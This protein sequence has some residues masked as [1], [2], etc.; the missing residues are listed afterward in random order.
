MALLDFNKIDLNR[1]IRIGL[2]FSLFILTI[3]S[4]VSYYSLQKFID[5]SRLVDHT[6]E[7]LMTLENTLSCMRAAESGQRGYI[8]TGNKIFLENY[9][10][11]ESQTLGLCKKIKHLTADNPIQQQDAELLLSNVATRYRKMATT[12][13]YYDKY[14][15]S[16]EEMLKEGRDIMIQCRNIIN[17]MKGEELR[18][19]EIRTTEVSK[20]AYYSPIIIV[21]SSLI[22]IFVSLLSFYFITRD[23]KTK[24]AIQ[25]ELTKLNADL[26]AYNL[27]ANKSRNELFKQN[28]ILSANTEL[29][30]I[31]RGE[32]DLTTAC[33][34]I[35]EYLCHVMKAQTGLMY[36]T[37]EDLNYRLIS[38]YA[39]EVDETIPSTFYLGDGLLGQCAQQKE[40]QLL[41]DLPNSS[42]KIKSGLS[43]IAPQH[44]LLVP[45][46]H[47][48]QTIALVELLNKDKFE[49]L[50]L[51]FIESIGNGIAT[52]IKGLRAEQKTAELLEE[53]QRQAEILEVQQ[54]E[55]R[56]SNEELE[57]QARYLKRQQEELQTANE[58]LEHQTLSVE[59]KN[60]ELEKAKAE[61]DKKTLDLELS[62]K[63]KSEFLANMSHELRTPLNSLLILSKDLAE[64]KKKNLEQFQVESAQIIYNSGQDLLQLINE[65]LDLSKIEAGKMELNVEKVT[66]E[67]FANSISRN[68]RHIAEKKGLK[69][70]T[71]IENDL[72]DHIFTD[73]Q[74]LEQIIRNLISNAIKFT[75]NGSISLIVQKNSEN[76]I[77]FSVKDTGIGISP[78]KHALIF[79]AFQ[80]AEGGTSRKYG[81]TGLGLS[82]S[83]EL[84][85]LIHGSISLSST[86]DVGSTFTLVIPNNLNASI[87]ITESTFKENTVNV[88]SNKSNL[89]NEERSIYKLDDDRAETT[90]G[91][92]SILI[93]EDDEVF[94]NIL[95]EQARERKFKVLVTATGEEGLLLAE[96]YAPKAIILDLTLPLMDGKAVLASLKGNPFL[97]HIPVHIISASDRTLDTIKRGAVEYLSKPVN[98]IDLENAFLRIENFINRKL[99]NLLIVEDDENSRRSIKLLIGETDV[100]CF[101]AGSG[102]EALD[103]IKNNHID[104]VVLDLGLPDMTGFQLIELLEREDKETIPPII[105]YTGRELTKAENEIL[106]NHAETII[107]KGVKSEERLLD[108]TAIFLHRTIEKLP[109]N[110]QH[111]ITELYDKDAIFLHKKILLV[112]DDM[113]NIFALSKVL[114]EAGMEIIK[115]ENGIK[116][117]EALDK[118]PEVDLVLMDIMMPEMDGYEAMRRIRKQSKFI[119]LPVIA[120]TAKAMKEDKNKCI[121]AGASDYFSKPI[122]IDRLLSLMRIWIKR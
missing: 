2:G 39:I 31:I 93:I 35:L 26:E 59:I 15:K 23:I 47:N 32:K 10:N 109:E 25:Q 88:Y 111:I 77:A 28:Y 19:L 104:C 11:G 27:E 41:E 49:P 57:E 122:D 45:F 17:K 121:E 64:N 18:L 70:I 6:N 50:N 120:L 98:R 68:F 108:E 44:I 101:E 22:A 38:R 119:D 7:V 48:N 106:Q 34:K 103:V 78:E 65:V 81:G 33:G 94:A 53:T 61:V 76:T 80:Q 92:K 105:V 60:K 66:T 36:T 9:M 115:A 20:Y 72:P 96:K 75:Q 43:S 55:L 110:Q 89:K 5:Q 69:F 95:M 51:E 40:K 91:D 118:H 56:Q 3:S 99:K 42:I 102:T 90:K 8:I 14:Q 100:K 63:Y 24:T 13:D 54:E 97:R 52:F 29:N 73:R 1:K 86:P 84:A 62:S 12:L 67:D 30:N 114:K 71:K 21:A 46:V 85:K 82:I 74:R 116:A 113:R 4:I 37:K 79:E 112:D 117:L 87:S 107:I 83:K 16:S 58:E